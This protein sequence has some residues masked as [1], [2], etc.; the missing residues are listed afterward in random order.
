MSINTSK[1]IE[2]KNSNLENLE[3]NVIKNLT[4]PENDPTKLV[5]NI[6]NQIYAQEIKT[7]VNYLILDFINKENV[8]D[9]DKQDFMEKIY[10]P[11]NNEELSQYLQY[12]LIDLKIWVNDIASKNVGNT[13]LSYDEIV[14]FRNK[15]NSEV[16]ENVAQK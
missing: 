10:L 5:N 13:W 3:K 14:M 4:N 1:T 7:E 8:T 11:D 9:Q 16:T 12:V 6:E 2:T 15:M